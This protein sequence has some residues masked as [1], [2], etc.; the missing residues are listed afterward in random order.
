MITLQLQS[1]LLM[2]CGT[3]WLPVTLMPPPSLQVTYSL[4]VD[5]LVSNQLLWLTVSGAAL[6][7][8]SSMAGTAVNNIVMIMIMYDLLIVYILLTH[9]HIHKHPSLLPIECLTLL[10][11]MN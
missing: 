9:I 3:P 6:A 2:V 7:R 1:W 5:I 10:R 11:Q 8:S 4:W